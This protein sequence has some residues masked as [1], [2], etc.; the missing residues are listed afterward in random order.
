M[1][2]EM[3]VLGSPSLIVLTV[4]GCKATLNLNERIAFEGQESNASTWDPVWLESSP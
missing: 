1:K 3:D 2:D 4:S